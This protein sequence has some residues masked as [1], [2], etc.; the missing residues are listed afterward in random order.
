MIIDSKESWA[1]GLAEEG[2][3]SKFIDMDFSDEGAVFDKCLHLI[4]KVEQ[5]QYSRTS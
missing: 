5:V 3:I 2:V 1:K 4:K